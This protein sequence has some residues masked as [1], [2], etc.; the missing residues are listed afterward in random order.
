MATE[1]FGISIRGFAIAEHDYIS[2]S[3][4]GAN[5]T[6]IVYKQGGASGTVVSTLA[7]TYDANGSVLTVTKS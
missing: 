1:P 6:T 4:T 7:L 3:Y 5:P 2:L